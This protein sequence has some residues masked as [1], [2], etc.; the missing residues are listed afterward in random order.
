MSMMNNKSV[1]CIAKNIP[2]TEHI[3]TQLKS[4]GFKDSDI[5]VLLPQGAT[6]NTETGT[7]SSTDIQSQRQ[8]GTS[9]EKKG[10]LGHEMHSKAPEGATAGGVTGGIIGGTLGLL[11]GIGALAIPGLG[12][13]IAAGPIM[14]ALAGSGLGGGIG[15]LIGSLVGMGIPEYEAVYYAEKLKN[16]EN[17]LIC[18][19]TNSSQ[20]IDQAKAV[21]EKN[22]A[23][24]IAYSREV[25]TPSRDK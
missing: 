3:V 19:H 8:A 12:P 11:A 4:A 13:F 9:T 16:K 10:G 5:S 14:G 7:Y 24:D 23:E 15:L 6:L 17:I 18:V 25:S 2:Q 1:Y 21:F 20:Q 22:G